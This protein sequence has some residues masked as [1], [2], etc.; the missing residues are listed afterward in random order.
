MAAPGG[1]IAPGWKKRKRKGG[2]P[3]SPGRACSSQLRM[4]SHSAKPVE[5]RP[6]PR[7]S[8]GRWTGVASA[9]IDLPA[10]RIARDSLLPL[11]ASTAATRSATVFKGLSPLAAAREPLNARLDRGA[12]GKDLFDQK[13]FSLRQLQLRRDRLGQGLALDTE[14]EIT[15]L[16]RF[17]PAPAARPLLP[18]CAFQGDGR[19]CIVLQSPQRFG[20]PNRRRRPEQQRTYQAYHLVNPKVAL[21]CIFPYLRNE[22]VISI[23]LGPERHGGRSRTARGHGRRSLQLLEAMIAHVADLNLVDGDD[24]AAA[25]FH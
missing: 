15:R 9:V 16:D 13:S 18:S 2:L 4:S 11:P 23:P 6:G 19:T 20:G 3:P 8:A 5:G 17:A 21:H 1:S 12:V 7:R 24:H 14:E 22:R 10:R 25:V